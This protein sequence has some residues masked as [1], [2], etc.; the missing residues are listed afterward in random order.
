M[1]AHRASY[2][3]KVLARQVIPLAPGYRTAL[4]SCPA[5]WSPIGCKFASMAIPVE[6]W[7]GLFDL[8]FFFFI[9]ISF[10]VGKSLAC[11]SPGKWCLCA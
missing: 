10:R 11:H 9:I 5:E 4:S 1:L 2:D 7:V 6:K 3:K 8:I